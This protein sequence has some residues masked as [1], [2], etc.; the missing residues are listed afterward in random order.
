MKHS[1][2]VILVI[3]VFTMVNSRQHHH[4]HYHHHNHGHEDDESRLT[5]AAESADV[6]AAVN[7]CSAAGL[8]CPHRSSKCV[9]QNKNTR[10]CY[11]DK[12]CRYF[13]DCCSDYVEFCR[14]GEEKIN[15]IC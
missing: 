5:S 1:V 8:C 6:G 10:A 3:L 4:H 13:H 2:F 15:F 7:L 12:S 9:V 14:S 11:C